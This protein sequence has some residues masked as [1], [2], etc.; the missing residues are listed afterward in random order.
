MIKI[1]NNHLVIRPIS[2]EHLKYRMVTLVNNI[3]LY[4]LPFAQR[5]DLK[6]SFLKRQLCEMIDMSINLIMGIIHNV[7]VYQIITLYTLNI[8]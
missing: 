8:L 4:A 6:H 2:S 3:V 7:Y 5:V 1:N